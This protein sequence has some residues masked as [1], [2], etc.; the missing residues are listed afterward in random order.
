MQYSSKERYIRYCLYGVVAV[1][2]VLLQFSD[3]SFPSIFGARAFLLIPLT[4]AVAMYEREV[5]AA[6]FGAITGLLWDINSANEG[7]STLVLMLLSAAAS[8]L[9]SHFMQNNIVTAFVLGGGAVA[10]YELLYIFV[11]IILSGAGG[12]FRLFFTF[13]LPSFVYTIIFVPVFY[14]LVKWIYSSHKATDE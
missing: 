7:F 9:I 11:N 12:A 2:T 1:A 3:I 4:I 5:P 6:V 10:I 8:I 13:Y 14:Y